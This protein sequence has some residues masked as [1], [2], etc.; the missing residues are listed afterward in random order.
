MLAFRLADTHAGRTFDREILN[1]VSRMSQPSDNELDLESLLLPAWAKQSADTNRYA[2]FRGD[3]GAR[4]ERGDRRGG[5]SRGP[6]PGGDRGPRRDGPR[7][8]GPGGPRPGG[9]GG[10]R[11]GGPGVARDTRIATAATNLA[12]KRP[13]R[14]LTSMS[15]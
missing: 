15:A 4:P 13:L 7:R 3:E 6:R 8:D 2:N 14:Y 10:P 5:P 1:S 11:S 12:A 9:Q